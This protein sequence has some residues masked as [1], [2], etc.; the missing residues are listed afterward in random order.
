MGFWGKYDPVSVV[1]SAAK[2]V[3]DA[4]SGMRSDYVREQSQRTKKAA[5]KKKSGKGSYP[6]VTAETRAD[7]S[8][9]QNKA[10]NYKRHKQAANKLR[11]RVKANNGPLDLAGRTQRAKDLKR[12]RAIDAVAERDRK[13][14]QGLGLRMGGGKAN[15]T[16][17]ASK[18]VAQATGNGGGGGSNGGGSGGGGGGS[19]T[20]TSRGG[21][22]SSGGSKPNAP[23]MGAAIRNAR[24]ARENTT[25]VAISA[26][27]LK[28]F[29]SQ[30]E[31]SH[32]GVKLSRENAVLLARL[33]KKRGGKAAAF[34]G[35]LDG[36]PNPYDSGAPGT[37][38]H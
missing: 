29:M 9:A 23:R 35:L 19:Q 4:G 17:Q 16:P 15:G 10:N 8:K 5:P 18:A 6:G 13:A 28:N 2:N 37:G 33:V 24:A 38:I 36:R 34:Y 27:E 22:S 7:T 14:A 31:N 21:G 30:Y 32:K 20:S 26:K 3:W 25:G 1:A 11:T 12:L